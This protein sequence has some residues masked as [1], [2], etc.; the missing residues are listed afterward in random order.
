MKITI[1][2]EHDNEHTANEV[3]PKITV[4]KRSQSPSLQDMGSEYTFRKLTE[5]MPP[6]E[7]YFG[8]TNAAKTYNQGRKTHQCGKCGAPNRRMVADGFCRDCR[9]KS[10]AWIR[11]S[12]GV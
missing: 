4:E 6:T 7:G 2:I 10:S 11:K 8:N 1:I 9:G 3:K 12:R 5:F